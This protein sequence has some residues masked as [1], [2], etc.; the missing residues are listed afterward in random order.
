M[1]TDNLPSWDS[2]YGPNYGKAAKQ[3]RDLGFMVRSFYM[4][5]SDLSK[6]SLEAIKER[7]GAKRAFYEVPVMWFKE[8]GKR[9][10]SIDMPNEVPERIQFGGEIPSIEARLYCIDA[11]GPN[12]CEDGK[13]I[14][15]FGLQAKE[16]IYDLFFRIDQCVFCTENPEEEDE[17]YIKREEEIAEGGPFW[18][19]IEEDDIFD[20]TRSP[21]CH[22]IGIVQ[23]EDLSGTPAKYADLI[24]LMLEQCGFRPEKGREFEKGVDIIAKVMTWDL[25]SDDEKNR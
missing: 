11:I 6:E 7:F 23:L 22:C 3:L 20:G 1:E 12:I 19:E 17:Y 9:S 10:I 13:A 2:E 18:Y 14:A 15:S 24:T 16:F 4:A 25:D 5:E 21:Y 8:A